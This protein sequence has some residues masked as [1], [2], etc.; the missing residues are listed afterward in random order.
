MFLRSQITLNIGIDGTP[1]KNNMVILSFD[2]SSVSS[3]WAV[4]KDGEYVKSGTI[5]KS[6]RSDIEN[7]V[8]EMC[9][10]LMNKIREVAP[11]V[12][13]IEELS[14]MRNAHTT[15]VLSKIIC[16]VYVFCLLH[17]IEYYE[18]S[19]P[20]WRSVLGIKGK[21]DVAK[22]EAIKYVKDNYGKAVCDDEADAVCIGASY[23]LR[24]ENERK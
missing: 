16:S 9:L 1:I 23:I 12:V 5:K 18:F 3:G 7:R 24:H 8:D 4:F 21:R 6:N 22:E 11:D 15:R 19:P 14:V 20:Q 13:C 2:T 10:E 17:Q